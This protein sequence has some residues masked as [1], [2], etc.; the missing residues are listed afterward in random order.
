M[1]SFSPARTSHWLQVTG[2][3]GGFRVKG[4]A[5]IRS[6]EKSEPFH[7]GLSHALAAPPGEGKASISTGPISFSN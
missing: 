1:L 2:K 7:H 3:V 5:V 4:S 6:G